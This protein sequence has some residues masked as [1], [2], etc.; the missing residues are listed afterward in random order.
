[1]KSKKISELID[2]AS[3]HLEQNDSKSAVSCLNEVLLLDPKNCEALFMMANCCH[4]QGQIGKAINLFNQVLSIQPDHT[5][6]AISLSVLYND[7]GK[8]DKAQAIFDRANE[9]VKSGSKNLGIQ[10]PHINKKFAYK[11]FELGDLYM[12]YNRF[13][14]ALFEYNKAMG[15]DP[16][17]LDLRVKI[18]K[19]YA[20]K[21]YVSKSFDE[22]KKLKNEHPGFL[23]ARISLGILYYANNKVLEAQNEWK[24]VLARD[25]R[26]EQAKMYLNLSHSATETS[27]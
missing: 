10:E 4:Q 3:K 20:K 9:K 14:E 26:N 6:A 25:G 24:G 15:L 19:A 12:T 8:Y 5:D 17:N 11:H 18:A 13:D 22:L 1:M 27:L 23:D 7:I 16:Q 21:G 2:F